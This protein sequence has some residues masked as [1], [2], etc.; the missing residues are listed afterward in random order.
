LYLF[1]NI[2]DGIPMSVATHL[3]SELEPGQ[4][5]IKVVSV[6]NQSRRVGAGHNLLSFP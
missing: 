6:I 1:D 4:D 3:K 5:H 2:F